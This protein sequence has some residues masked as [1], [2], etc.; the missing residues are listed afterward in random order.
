MSDI[1]FEITIGPISTLYSSLESPYQPMCH[2]GLSF[3]L[4]SIT[5]SLN[6]EIGD[7]YY[8]LQTDKKRDRIHQ[9]IYL[10]AMSKS[11]DCIGV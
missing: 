7:F 11:S 6:R 4:F 10:I 5:Y 9:S 2:D 8:D 3:I 1:L